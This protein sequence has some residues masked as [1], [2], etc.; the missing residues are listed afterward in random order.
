MTDW[1]KCSD[2]LP[3]DKEWVLS[4]DGSDIYITKFHQTTDRRHKIRAGKFELSDD[5]CDEITHWMPLPELPKEPNDPNP[6]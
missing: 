1:I 6:S 4:F 2:R 3:L 5:F